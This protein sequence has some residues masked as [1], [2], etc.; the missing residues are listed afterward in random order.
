M[1]TSLLAGFGL[2]I[3]GIINFVFI[4]PKYESRSTTFGIAVLETASL[5]LFTYGIILVFVGAL[6]S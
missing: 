3:L 2:I 6:T 1:S 5:I 4:V